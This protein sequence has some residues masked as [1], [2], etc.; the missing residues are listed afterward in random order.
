MCDTDALRTLALRVLK[1]PKSSGWR[2][3][4]C[5]KLE[6]AARA[7]LVLQLAPQ[8]AVGSGAPAAALLARQQQAHCSAEHVLEGLE[9]MAT[10]TA[11]PNNSPIYAGTRVERWEEAVL[12]KADA[13]LRSPTGRKKR[14][15][16][17]SCGA[18]SCSDMCKRH[19]DSF[20]ELIGVPVDGDVQSIIRN[21]KRLRS[22]LCN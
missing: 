18:V 1:A 10:D 5:N 19:R 16:C 3:L 2:E 9:G 12:S 8:R 4:M 14:S 17:I 6:N 20:N 11:I 15:R 21:T 7:M 13:E 22:S